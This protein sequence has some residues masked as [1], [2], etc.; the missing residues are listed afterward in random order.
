MKQTRFKKILSLLLVF[1]LL[2]GLLPYSAVAAETETPIALAAVPEGADPLAMSEDGLR[3]ICPDSFGLKICQKARKG[4][5]KG[6][7]V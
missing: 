3:A 7:Q 2:T 6:Q 5:R 1:C 4:Q